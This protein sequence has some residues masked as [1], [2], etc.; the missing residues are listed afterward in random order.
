VLLDP[1]L[2]VVALLGASASDTTMVLDLLGRAPS[3]SDRPEPQTIPALVLSDVFE[4]DFCTRLM[5]EYEARGFHHSGVFTQG[6]AG[7]TTRAMDS[8]FK[9]RRDCILENKALLDGARARIL[10]RIVPEIARVFQARAGYLE[11]VII[12]S[13]DGAERGRFGA[14][15]DNTMLATEHR[16][17]AISINLNDRFDGGDLVFPEYGPKRIRPPAGG[18]AVFSCGLLH[19]VEP[20]ERGARFACLTFAYDEAAAALRRQNWD[21]IQVQNRAPQP[22]PHGSAAAP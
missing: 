15:R 16:Q 4:P 8:G 7:E 18:A 20:V 2:H 21:R 13:Y 12:A 5:A 6:A 22:A 17:F 11:R 19:R 9:R 3:F 14:H 10:R 1:T